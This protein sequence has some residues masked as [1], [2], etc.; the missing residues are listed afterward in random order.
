MGKAF[1]KTGQDIESCF[2]IS[3][4][5]AYTFSFAVIYNLNSLPLFQFLTYFCYIFF[6]YVFIYILNFLFSSS[7]MTVELSLFFLH[8]TYTVQEGYLRY[9]GEACYF[10]IIWPVSI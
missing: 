8:V 9:F 4:I 1:F 6:F 5:G 7:F 10:W 2:F 3:F